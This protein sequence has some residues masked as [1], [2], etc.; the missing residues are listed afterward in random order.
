MQKRRL[1]NLVII[2]PIRAGFFH[3]IAP[4]LFSLG[5][6]CRSMPAIPGSQMV[7]CYVLASY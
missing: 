6:R 5:W 3:E 7:A 2:V 4:S 1:T